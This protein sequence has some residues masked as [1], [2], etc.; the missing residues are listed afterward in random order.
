MI[1]NGDILTMEGENVQ[2]Y[3]KHGVPIER[4]IKTPRISLTFRNYD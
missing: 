3:C 1:G 4:K 2:K